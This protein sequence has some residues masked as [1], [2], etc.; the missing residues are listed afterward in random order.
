MNREILVTGFTDESQVRRAV[1]VIHGHDW[2]VVDIYAPYALHAIEDL[3]SRRRSRLPVACFLGG[4]AG[5]VL[6][7]WLQFWTSTRSWPLNVGGR[8]WNSLPA[9]VPVAFECMVLLGGL[10]VVGALLLRSRLYPG[11]RAFLPA[12]GITD[13][14]FA[15]IVSTPASAA[16][17]QQAL[18]EFH[19][20]CRET[21][22]E[23]G[24][25]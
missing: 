11:R 1:A 21:T 9:F 3:L 10:S 20:E 14:R 16:E 15:I 5:L 6:A 17:V 13:D 25:S 24:H 2:A 19:V 12:E 23:D 7:L 8:P 4:S 18:Q 22:G